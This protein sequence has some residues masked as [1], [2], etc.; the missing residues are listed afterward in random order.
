V[1]SLPGVSKRI[2][3]YLERINEGGGRANRMDFLRIAGNE[4]NLNDWID[5]MVRCNLIESEVPEG[6]AKTTYVMTEYGR[7]VHGVLKDYSYLGPLFSDLSRERRRR[8]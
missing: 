4:S 5:Y 3:H 2:L 7:K 1:S 6:G 8:Q